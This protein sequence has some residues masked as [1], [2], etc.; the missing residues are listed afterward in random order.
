MEMI[1]AVYLE[2]AEAGTKWHPAT[3]TTDATRKELILRPLHRHE[4]KSLRTRLSSLRR[5]RGFAEA[6]GQSWPWHSPP[7]LAVGGFLLDAAERGPTAAAGMIANLLWWQHQ[8]GVPLGLEDPALR[9]FRYCAH[10]HTPRPATAIEP[11]QVLNL[12]KLAKTSSG[13][14][15]YLTRFILLAVALCM[16]WEHLLRCVNLVVGDEMITGTVT[17]GKRRASGSRPGFEWAVVKFCPANFDLF[18][19]L[20]DL[21]KA[22]ADEQGR[23]FII[24]DLTVHAGNLDLAK[25]SKRPMPY[26]KFVG[27]L[28][29]LTGD[30]STTFNSL[31]RFLP[32]IANAYALDDADAQ[33]ISNWQQIDHRAPGS[34]AIRQRAAFPMSRHYADGK[35]AFAAR[36][37]AALLAG[38]YKSL[39]LRSNDEGRASMVKDGYLAAKALTFDHLRELR[40]RLPDLD[41][42]PLTPKRANDT[43]TE[44]PALVAVDDATENEESSSSSSSS[45]DSEPD[46]APLLANT[47]CFLQVDKVHFTAHLVEGRRVPWCRH[48]RGNPFKSDPLA[49]RIGLTVAAA[50]GQTCDQCMRAATAAAATAI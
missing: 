29:R 15:G 12:I 18:G 46:E 36:L 24:P 28:R 14:V 32:S 50:F 19:P 45:S 20:E 21:W 34:A 42:L 31:R 25:W 43:S 11:W 17:H 44:P 2:V 9:D 22:T 30:S 48:R 4:P 16:R 39:Q 26:N 33:A 5:W 13:P 41:S 8:L 6:M 49:V 3:A 7:T 40:H 1:Y 47:E 38:M 10:G 27:Y 35:A 23:V 37:K